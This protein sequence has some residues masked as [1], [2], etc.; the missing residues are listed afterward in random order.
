VK[1]EEVSKE[2]D[3]YVGPRLDVSKEVTPCHSPFVVKCYHVSRTSFLVPITTYYIPFFSCHVYVVLGL[4]DKEGER[5]RE[6]VECSSHRFGF[7]GQEESK[8]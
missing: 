4:I 7:F 8:L 2:D 5:R 1:E 3:D 6:Y